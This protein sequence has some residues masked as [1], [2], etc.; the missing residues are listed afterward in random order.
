MRMRL[1]RSPATTR[2]SSL[3]A[4]LHTIRWDQRERQPRPA[5]MIAPGSLMTQ[6]LASKSR[7]TAISFAS[8]G[9]ATYANARKVFPFSKMFIGGVQNATGEGFRSADG[10]KSGSRAEAESWRHC[11]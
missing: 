3:S 8:P 10:G 1:A 4:H 9:A 2:K 5:V 11:G 6:A 7:R